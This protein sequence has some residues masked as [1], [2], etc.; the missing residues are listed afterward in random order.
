M[1]Y[2]Y[3]IKSLEQY[4]EAYKKSFENP[5]AFWGEIAEQFTWHKKWDKVLEWNFKE[6]KVEWFKGAEI[7]VAYNCVDRHAQLTPNATALIWESD[8]PEEQ[9]RKFSYAELLREVSSFS[10]VLKNNEL[11]YSFLTSSNLP[12]SSIFRSAVPTP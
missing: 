12:F 8:N 9:S 1:S 7:N 4:H 2:P 10:N 11:L 3:Q 5:E 6:P